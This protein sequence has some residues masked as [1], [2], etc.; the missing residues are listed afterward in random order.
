MDGPN[1]PGGSGAFSVAFSRRSGAS[2]GK[3]ADAVPIQADKS[4]LLG[5]APALDLSF[6]GN[7]VR[8]AFEVLGPNQ[9]DGTSRKSIT[10]IGACIVLIDTP[11]R[12]V[13]GR[14]PDIV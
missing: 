9:N 8:D 2:T 14:T 7:S 6:D 10:G 5:A 13:S 12:I 1:S 3:R 4:F 11:G